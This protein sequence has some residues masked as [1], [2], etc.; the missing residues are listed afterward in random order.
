MDRSDIVVYGVSGYTGKLIAE[1]LHNRS[2]PFTA[3]GRNAEKIAGA[4]AIAAER[5]GVE[6]DAIDAEIVTVTHDEPSLTALF[7]DAKVVVN[8]TGP[9]MQMGEVV[10][11]SALAAGCHYLDTTGEQ[12]FMLAMRDAYGEAFASKG[13]LLAPACSYMWTMGALAAEV[14]LE[15]SAIDSLELTYMSAQG[16]PSIASSQSFMRMLAAPHYYLQHNE[17][18]SWPLGK[19]WDVTLPGHAKVFKGSSWGGAGEPAWYQ[20]DERVRNCT[21]YQCGDDNDM[22]EMV[23]AGVNQILEGAA[24]DENAREEMAIAGAGAIVQE[25]PPKEDPLMHRGTVHCTGSGSNGKNFCTLN[26]H[27]PYVMTGEFIAHG[28]QHLLARE[29][30]ETGFASPAC[31]FGHRELLEMLSKQHFV[32]VLEG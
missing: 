32:E 25:E 26:F 2:M 21:V 23:I 14:T 3:A 24:G 1:S 17:M 18:V 8:V 28:C 7:S 19:T 11:R 31:A 27:S 4:L 9:F 13:L 5:A 15:N 22:M 10:V 16:A 12:D 29:P 20:H 6:A 30:L